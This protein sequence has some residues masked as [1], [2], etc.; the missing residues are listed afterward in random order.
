[1][2]A[3]A[4]RLP[5]SN[6][7]QHIFLAFV[8]TRQL[9][10]G[11]REQWATEPRW[12]VSPGA[13]TC[14]HLKLKRLENRCPEWSADGTQPAASQNNRLF[15]K[16]VRFGIFLSESLDRNRLHHLILKRSVAPV[17]SRLSDRIDHIHSLDHFA[18]SSI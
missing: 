18:E 17:R 5:T 15:G 2:R 1:M 13:G 9:E 4:Y 7:G 10:P 11:R 14:M 6:E 8:R 3:A 16:F 12:R